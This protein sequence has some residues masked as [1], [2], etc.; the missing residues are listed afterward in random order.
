[1]GIQAISGVSTVDWSALKEAQ[2]SSSASA[3]GQ[4]APAKGGGGAPPA[5]GGGKAASASG[6]ESSSGSSA[7]IYDPR[8]TNKDG[9]VSY[10]EAM[11]YAIQHPEAAEEES[12][13]QTTP[14]QAGVNAYKQGNQMGG[15]AGSVSL[16]G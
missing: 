7:Q 15:A 11:M 2:S 1:M 8:D 6:T 4:A 3:T 16:V 13:T 12:T 14:L 9:V 10:E 5:G